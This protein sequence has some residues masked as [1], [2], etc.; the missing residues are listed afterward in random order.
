MLILYRS[1]DII[2]PAQAVM[3]KLLTQIFRAKQTQPQP[4]TSASNPGASSEAGPPSASRV[5]ILV[6]RYIFGQFRVTVVPETCALIYLQGQIRAGKIEPEDFPL[7]LWDMERVYEGVYQYLEFF[8]VLTEAEEWKHLLVEW[9]IT[10]EL[11]A[12]LRELHAGIPSG[13]LSAHP[14]SSGAPVDTT[15]SASTAQPRQHAPMAVERPYDPSPTSPGGG[16]G[17]S[18][19]SSPPAVAAGAADSPEAFEW[20]NLKKLVVLVL[21]SLVWKAGA[22]QD[23]VRL[24]GGVEAVLQCCNFDGHNPYIREH[25]IMCLRFLLEGNPANMHAV[26]QL[27]PRAAVPSEVLDHNGFETFIDPAGKV[28]LRMKPADAAAVPSSSKS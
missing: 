25:A 11:I 24:H 28:G 12:L 2:S 22:V 18:A 23:Q 15:P 10:H 7:N 26:G 21:S 19:P 3:I 9:E 20:R 5:D 1:K 16:D 17:P 27:Q 8:A 6:V 13:P 4:A 14:V